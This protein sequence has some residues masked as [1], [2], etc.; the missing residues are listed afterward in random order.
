MVA[1]HSTAWVQ[2]PQARPKHW[3]LLEIPVGFA[4]WPAGIDAAEDFFCGDDGVGDGGVGG[5]AGFEVELGEAALKSPPF[6]PRRMGI[7]RPEEGER[8]ESPPFE[9]KDGYPTT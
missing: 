7:R 2:E 8:L 3:T 1:G 4:V 9:A 6:K 5:G